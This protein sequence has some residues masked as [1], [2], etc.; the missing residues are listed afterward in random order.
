MKKG[1]TG[2]MPSQHKGGKGDH[3]QKTKPGYPT[4][5]PERT[6]GTVQSPNYPRKNFA[7]KTFTKKGY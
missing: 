6:S 1:H 7:G 4:G 5:T 2:K 3:K